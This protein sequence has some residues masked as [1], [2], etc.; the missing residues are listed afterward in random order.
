MPGT[1]RLCQLL[2][3][4]LSLEPFSRVFALSAITIIAFA[5]AISKFK[6]KISSRLIQS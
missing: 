2:D 5:A 6:D 3:R 1:A 4:Y